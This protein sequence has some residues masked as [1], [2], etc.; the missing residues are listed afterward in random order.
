[1]KDLLE[2]SDHIARAIEE[3]HPVVALESTVIAHGLPHPLNL[4]TARECQSVIESEGAVAATVGI[5]GGRSKIG[6]SESEIEV[7]ATGSSKDGLRIEKVGLNNLGAVLARGRWGATTVAGTMRLASLG[8]LRVFSTGGIGGVHKGAEISFDISSDL[9]ALANIPM[10]CVCAGAKA[11]LD[12][13]KTME[14]LETL[15]VPVVGYRTDELPAFYSRRS[16]LRVDAA[17]ETEEEAA[18]LCARHWQ[19]G[20]RTAVLVC[21]PVHQEDE[22]APDEIE[23]LINEAISQAQRENVHGKAVTPFVLSRLEKLSAG[24]TLKTNRA[25]LINNARVAARIA[26]SLISLP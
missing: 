14:K 4:E 22:I 26:A 11:I 24:R 7:F 5:V 15:G 2:V 3:N 6:L 13:P 10:V 17:I 12:L 1:M 20:N 23:Q 25:L 21:V 8:G 18:R 9:T 16:G 19:M